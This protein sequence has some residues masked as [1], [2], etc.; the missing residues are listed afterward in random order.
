MKQESHNAIDS[1]LRKL[2]R[3]VGHVSPSSGNGAPDSNTAHLD[4]DELNAYAENVLPTATRARYTEHLADC[5]RC[6]QTVAQ[7]SQ[8]A[9]LVFHETPQ[10]T[11]ST[12]FRTFLN[13]L[14]SPMV[15]RY[16]LPAVAL[17][18][19]AIGFFVLRQSSPMRLAEN[20]KFQE[21]VASQA[22]ISSTPEQPIGSPSTQVAKESSTHNKNSPPPTDNE[23]AKLADEGQR[24]EKEQSSREQPI[25]STDKIADAEPAKAPS[26]TPVTSSATQSVV[27]DQ[28]QAAA[29]EVAQNNVAATPQVHKF[30]S[31]RTNEQAAATKPAGAASVGGAFGMTESGLKKA[32]TDSTARRSASKAADAP[33]EEKE[34]D[35]ADKD[36]AETTSVAGHR[37]RKSG[38]I[39][40]DVSYNSSQPATT[41]VRGSEQYRALIG[42]EPGIRTIAEQLQGEVIVVWKDRAYRIK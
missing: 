10:R 3:S 19:I 16:A 36:E 26:A 23:R 31:G 34:R 17:F 24:Q 41:V 25:T 21:S 14:F 20:R 9:G 35:R 30:E 2:G 8:A 15:L 38:S 33:A 5:A 40:I 29:P 6:R 32:K 13:S 28:K 37:F 7:L 1:M 27:V 12:G 42:D 22:P 11:P 39:W 18:A 4:T